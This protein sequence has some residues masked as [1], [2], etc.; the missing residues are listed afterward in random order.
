MSRPGE[1]LL[2]GW[3]GMDPGEGEWTKH[4]TRACGSSR[5]KASR[6]QVPGGHLEQVLMGQVIYVRGERAPS[7][8]SIKE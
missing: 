7:G 1:Q 6:A 4:V 3:P 2:Q 5:V 8:Q